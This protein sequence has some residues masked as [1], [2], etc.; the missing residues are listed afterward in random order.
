MAAERKKRS[1]EE[2]DRTVAS[3]KKILALSDE[4]AAKFHGVLSE[5]RKQRR[6]GYKPGGDWRQSRKESRDKQ[7]KEVE[8]V[9][10]PEQ[11]KQ[12]IDV[13]ELERFDR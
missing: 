4:Q 7:N 1:E 2:L 13:S 10:S 11:Y 3:Y 6:E 9:L 12:Y 8:K 5:G